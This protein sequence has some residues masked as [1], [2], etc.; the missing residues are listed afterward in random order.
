[1]GKSQ[2]IVAIL[3]KQGQH[4][5]ARSFA[6]DDRSKEASA[7]GGR[8]GAQRAAWMKKFQDAAVKLGAHPGKLN[9]DS[10]SYLF[11]QGMRPDKAAKK[12][13]GSFKKDVIAEMLRARRPDLATAM[14]KATAAGASGKAQVAIME[15]M[16]GPGSGGAML[17]DMTADPS[18]RGVHFAKIQKA[19]EVLTKKGLIEFDGAN[20][21][22]A[23]TVT[24]AE[25]SAS[26]VTA[27]PGYSRTVGAGKFDYE[28]EEAGVRLVSS[29]PRVHAHVY[30]PLANVGKRGKHVEVT[31]YQLFAPSKKDQKEATSAVKSALKSKKG[32]STQQ[33]LTA[34]RTAFLATA[35]KSVET[36][37]KYPA[38]F[39]E[40]VRNRV[41]GMDPS[42]PDASTSPVY[43]S[44]RGRDVGV[45]FDKP[46]IVIT[47]RRSSTVA[48]KGGQYHYLT[49]SWPQVKKVASMAQGL[50]KL[51]GL[52][53]V[54]DALTTAGI[55]YKVNQY[56]D[57]M[58]S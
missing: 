7:A 28:G 19:A 40:A 52:E 44:Q 35:R 31:S 21:T 20:L 9:W 16:K 11:L 37:A 46:S 32:A 2:E 3:K 27:A 43:S 23:R 41:G 57:P 48:G 18:F 17:T 12:V 22:L 10:A 36:Q 38:R 39:H 33:I 42:I 53:A 8:K 30:Y 14:S 58:W 26:V 51:R 29:P 54:Q 1:M 4:C 34:V 56:A 50:T 24:V 6:S 45:V 55:K 25:G 5:L 47:S 49:V 13:H 15:Y